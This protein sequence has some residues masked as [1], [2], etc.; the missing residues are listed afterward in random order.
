MLDTSCS[1]HLLNKT[2][3]DECKSFTC[4]NDDLNDFFKNEAENYTKQLIAK[5]Y[6]FRL[7][8]NLSVMI[9]AFT[10]SNSKIK[11][12]GLKK[13]RKLLKTYLT[14]KLWRGIRLF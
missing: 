14:E 2:V 1:F 12:K 6:C 11:V 8:T 13:G 9:C 5:S 3:I 7:K 10:L 4:G